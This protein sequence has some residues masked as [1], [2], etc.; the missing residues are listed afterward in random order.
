V[1]YQKIVSDWG[2]ALEEDIGTPCPSLA[3]CFPLF[4]SLFPSHLPC[5]VQLCFT[6]QFLPM[7]IA[8]LQAPQQWAN[9]GLKL[10]KL[11]AKTN[12]LFV[13]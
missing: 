11:G 5:G 7:I 6:T 9:H 4:L 13:F 1:A 3:L 12:V 2:C 8:L 10:P